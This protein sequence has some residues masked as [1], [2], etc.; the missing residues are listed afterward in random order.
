[1][2]NR[3]VKKY[4]NGLLL[5][6]KRNTTKNAVFLDI[7]FK[8]GLNNDP[9]DKLGLAHLAEH[10]LCFSNNKY[11]LKEKSEKLTKLFYANFATSRTSLRLYAYVS[12]EEFEDTFEFFANC[13]SD[14]VVSNE[15]FLNEKQV[16]NQEI[17]RFRK[18][19]AAE[20]DYTVH[21]NLYKEK[22]PIRIRPFGTLETV[23]KIEAHDVKDYL[24]NCLTLSNCQVTVYG[25]VSLLRAKRA[26]KKNLLGSLNTI[27]EQKF[28]G[29][30]DTVKYTY[31]K[32]TM[33]LNE[34]PDGGKSKIVIYHRVDFKN[35]DR[36]RGY[37]TSILSSI[38]ETAAKE[39][40]RDK[41]GLCYAARLKFKSVLSLD[42]TFDIITMTT[43]I[44]C[45]KDVVKKTLE[46]LPEFYAFVQ[47]YNINDEVVEQAKTILRRYEKC[48]I[49][50]DFI[51]KGESLSNSEF[52]GGIYYTNLQNLK[53][54]QQ[55][56]K[57][58]AKFVKDIFKLAIKEQPFI[59][60]V[61]NTED[62]LPT[63]NKIIKGINRNLKWI[64]NI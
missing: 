8:S 28:L 9:E 34:S 63:Y 40:F 7:R 56:E 37:A 54:K 43:T 14:V 35:L 10:S 5:V 31:T 59:F 33:I 64:N 25:N 18:N 12:D 30:N 60:V 20:M 24:I 6:Y 21:E 27:S 3:I 4:D 51:K 41:Y 57:I 38:F 44:E 29:P 13:L 11:T 22:V 42:N 2:K 50:K 19:L 52:Y 48:V 47:N 58:S 23:S 17:L 39:F 36:L 49:G 53:Y 46:V 15:E 26:I 62:E 16:V 45:D 1:M 61:S 55:R 32:P